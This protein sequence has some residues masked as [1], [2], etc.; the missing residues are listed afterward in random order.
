MVRRRRSRW[1]TGSN[2][3][4]ILF[5]NR[6][7]VL[8]LVVI[9][10]FGVIS[11]RLFSL[12]IL[13]GE[14]YDQKIQSQVT[15]AQEFQ[16]GRGDILVKDQNT[17]TYVKLAI[18]TSLDELRIDSAEIPDK[19]MVAD[20]ITPI[21][22][23]EEEYQLC[24]EDT[25][26]CP[27]E[28]VV[29]SPP[30][31]DEEGTVVREGVPIF[32]SFEEALG[33]KRAEILRKISKD[34][35]YVLIKRRLAPEQSAA[36]RELKNRYERDHK[37][38]RSRLY[39]EKK[40]PKLAVP[41][42]FKGVI[43][44]PQPMRYYPEHDLAAQIIGFVN[45]QGVGQYGIEEKMNS[46]LSG[47]KGKSTGKTDTVGRSIGLSLEDFQKAIDGSDI[48]LTL[49]RIVQQKVEEVLSEAVEKFD[50]DSGQ[51]IIM[52]PKTG[53]IIAMANYPTFDPNQF[54]N[55]YIVRR[56]IPEDFNRTYKTTAI[57]K[58]NPEDP[59]GEL[60]PA[61]FDEYQEAWKLGFDPEFYV[62]ENRTGPGAYLNKAVQE[63]YEPGSVFKPL[64][65]AIAIDNNEVK[66]STTYNETGPIE[67]DVGGKLVPIRNAD[68]QYLPNQTMTNVLERSANLGMVF[69]AR[70]IGKAL[71]YDYLKNFGFGRE[72]YIELADEISG[73]LKYYT[74]WST[75][76]LFNQAFGQG[77]SA[78]PLQVVTA[79]CALANGG[80]LPEPH[81]IAEI[82]HPDGTIEMTVPT[83]KSVLKA[84]T[85][86]T[87][88]AMLVS[89]VDHGYAKK[90][91]TPGYKIAGK[92]G[93][94]QIARIDGDGYENTSEEGSVITG[95]V[96]YG[97]ADD[98]Q[99]VM[100]VKFD[101]PRAG[102]VDRIWGETTA[103]P[104]FGEISAF[105]LDYYDIPP[106][107]SRLD[108]IQAE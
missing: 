28:S 68:K 52:D 88:T 108:E 76:Q 42:Y 79:W 57:L 59:E 66:P 65:M 41:D 91:G 9:S 63:I 49:D 61:T 2:S 99:Y 101:R 1:T 107:V 13:Q 31:L 3:S 74:Q 19:E 6:L 25:E 10:L 103:A 58:K 97:P 87:L 96:G 75:A 37:R 15:A 72:T 92:T 56:M 8:L 89:S 43:L 78:T 94:S 83:H 24:F 45:H 44:E 84:D 35:R 23:Q 81:I 105:L 62:Y 12:Q 67:V 11:I 27:E 48:V 85:A 69:V 54:G 30:V 46:L 90:G 55:V 38:D 95:Y 93:T 51:I 34:N 80:L 36:I 71:M 106:D 60:I 17:G 5:P 64:V 100:L 86:A 47:Q 70:K 102:G 4:K 33:K 82:H 73:Q 104:V 40:D 18:N 26:N 7:R 77:L 98:P 39:A 14:A 50:A 29:F 53:F 21:I 32:P 20:L 16:A 22:F